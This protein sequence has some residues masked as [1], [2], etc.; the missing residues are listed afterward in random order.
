MKSF[1]LV[2]VALFGAPG[3]AAEVS[4]IGKVLEM[5]SGLQA[6]ILKEGENAQ[7]VYADYAEWCED[8]A[9]D[10]GHEIKAGKAEVQSLEAVIAEETANQESLNTK[11]DELAAGIA[12]DEADLKAATHIREKEHEDFV[13]AEAELVETVDMLGRAIGILEREMAKG[14]AAMLQ[15][16]NAAGVTQAL[17]AMVDASLMASADASKLA[18]FVQSAQSASEGDDSVEPN[19]PA[20]AVYEGHSGDII[21][22]L[23]GLKD[24]AEEQLDDAR[25][26]ETNNL[27]TFQRLKQSLEDEIKFANQDLTKAKK[28][29]AESAETKS[30]A[31]GEFQATSKDLAEDV[32]AKADL[33]QACMTKAQD[34][35]AETN[36]RGEELKA[37]AEAKKVIQENTGGAEGIS[38]GLN[39]VSLLQTARSRL[40]SGM[41]LANLEAVRLVRGL[42]MREKSPALAQ[43]AQR[44][45]AAMR[46]GAADPFGKVKGLIS[47]MIDRLE[48]EAEQDA[49]HKAYCD[50][51]LGETEEKKAD[52]EADINKQTTRIDQMSSKSSM[53]KEEVAQLQADLAALAKAQAEMDALREKEHTLFVSSKADM[54][55]GLKG[56]KL[57]LKVLNEYYAKEGKAHTAASGAGSSIIGLLEVVES[58]FSK[59]LAEIETAEETAA[60]DYDRESKENSVEKTTKEKD[61][62]YKQKETVYLDKEVAELSADR[63]GVQAELDAVNE[64]LSKLHKEC[65]EVAETY[66]ERK[67]RFKAE[68]AGL[69]EALATLENETALLQRRAVRQRRA[70]RGQARLTSQ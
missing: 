10:L 52:K 3:L 15:V 34:F 9:R 38:Y 70:L 37:L 40:S 48:A 36:S 21:S 65:D 39:Q 23:E 12:T 43:L 49:S 6:K 47:D 53:L 7:K 26:T 61:V 11:V 28:G 31:D 33:H 54:E 14:G 66:A 45:S 30:K 68:I 35:E 46:S 63:S 5:L 59:D 17:T 22:T 27:H 42:A 56:V 60:A 44:L 1:A 64:Y 32:E 16:Q 18:A 55:Q 4:P 2:S 50:K 57:A 51:E 29:L 62:E 58:D 41:D 67:A 8:R 24:K 13:S 69:K 25:K 19:A 20:A